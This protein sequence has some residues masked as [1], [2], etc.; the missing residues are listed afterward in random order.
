MMTKLNKLMLIVFIQIISIHG[1]TAGPQYFGS[2]VFFDGHLWEEGYNIYLC[3]G[4][5]NIEDP[6]QDSVRFYQLTRVRNTKRLY[7]KNKSET[8]PEWEGANYFAMIA[9]TAT[10][11]K[12]NGLATPKTLNYTYND[13]ISQAKHYTTQYTDD[14]H[15]DPALSGLYYI[16]LTQNG[17]DTF[18]MD[19]VDKMLS[20]KTQTLEMQVFYDET[21]CMNKISPARI[22]SV[23]LPFSSD[24][25]GPAYYIKS[26]MTIEKG[27][28]NIQKFSGTNLAC[29]SSL[30]TL[31]CTDLHEAYEFLGWWDETEQKIMSTETKYLYEVTGDKT[32][33][34][35]FRPKAEYRHRLYLDATQWKEEGNDHRF[36]AYAYNDL[37]ESE[38]VD[39]ELLTCSNL[40]TYYIGYVPAKYH[41]I[42]FCKMNPNSTTNDDS[43]V[44]AQAGDTLITLDERI[45]YVVGAQVTNNIY[46]GKWNMP[47]SF[48][49]TLNIQGKGTVT[50]NDSTY[51]ESAIIPNVILHTPITAITHADRWLFV[52][53]TTSYM[54][55]GS[56]DTIHL[57]E[58]TI[59]NQ[60]EICGSTTINVHFK[61][62]ICE[63]QFATNLPKEIEPA[64]SPLYV[65]YNTTI[66]YPSVREVTGYLFEGWYKDE[67]YK[68]RFDFNAPITEDIVLY[69]QW[70]DFSK[71]VFFK[72]NVN[73]DHV[74][75]YTFNDDAW[76]GNAG[77]KLHQ[78][79]EFGEM[80]QMGKTDIF[81][82]ILKENNDFS[83]IAFSDIDMHEAK[84]F[85][86]NYAIYRTDHNS[87]MP[88]FIPLR[89]QEVAITNETKYQSQ[90]IWMKYKSPESGYYWSRRTTE[91][92]ENISFNAQYLG[93]YSYL[94]QVTLFE[95]DTIE[96]NV[97][98]LNGEY[99]GRSGTMMVSD[100]SNWHLKKT[101]EEYTTI[102]SKYDGVYKFII[103]FGN[104]DIDISLVFPV[105]GY[106]GNNNGRS[107]Y[108]IVYTDNTEERISRIIYNSKNTQS[109]D[110]T[111]SFFVRHDQDPKLHIEYCHWRDGNYTP[112][113]NKDN[114]TK[115]YELKDFCPETGVY[116]FVFYQN[117]SSNYSSKGIK[118]E[119][120]HKYTGDYYIRS[121]AAEGG[122]TS[123]KL[124]KHKMTHSKYAEDNEDYNYYFYKWVN[125]HE[126]VKYTIADD[127]STNLSDTLVAD[128]IISYN[129]EGEAGCVPKDAHVRFMWNSH[130]NELSRSYISGYPNTTSRFLVLEGND[131]LKNTEG[132]T[133]EYG[134][135]NNN[136]YGLNEHEEIFTDL[137]D[138]KYQVDVK[139]N[140]NTQV[141]VSAQYND[142]VQYFK[143]GPTTSVN[144]LQGEDEANYTMR[145]IYD[146]RT[147]QLLTGWMPDDIILDSTVNVGSNMLIIRRNNEQTNQV[148]FKEQTIQV[149]AVDR[150]YSVMTFTKEFIKNDELPS[151]L[152]E[153]YWISFPYDVNLSD[154]FGFG[155]YG[156]HWILQYYDG[157]ERA[158]KGLFIDS[159]TY[160]KY[161]TDTN[162]MLQK[163]VGYVLVLDL[164]EVRKC[165]I[166]DVNE[167][168]LYFPSIGAIS[169]SNV[170]SIEVPAHQCNIT[171]RKQDHTITD[172]HWNLIG[173]PCY[174]D[175]NNLDVTHK[176]NQEDVTFY[177]EYDIANDVYTTTLN[178]ADFRTMY[179]YMVQFSGVIKWRGEQ[180]GPQEIIARHEEEQCILRLNIANHINQDHT[181][182]QLK[183]YGATKDFDMNQDLTKIL[184][185]GTNIYT[186]IGEN[187][188]QAA[189]N[190]LPIEQI[191]LPV[192][193]QVAVSGDYT[194]SMPDGTSGISAVLLDKKHDVYTNLLHN[195]YCVNLEAGVYDGRFYLIL[196]PSKVTTRTEEI[197]T[198]GDYI[199]NKYLIDG[200]LYIQVNGLLYDIFGRP[201]R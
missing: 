72:N 62:D 156:K 107:D 52:D 163:G 56:G 199:F 5:E 23:G 16:T 49:I 162:T 196:D 121:N 34:A 115:I 90:G 55:L 118:I 7:S 95:N 30:D 47:P 132:N 4:K 143:G 2:W 88:L 113:W 35:R 165:F 108:R 140:K 102:N 79:K 139:A 104:G 32:V 159:G 109:K 83:H 149:E 44:L 61:Q 36:A 197:V 153:L 114:T 138:A 63:I 112:Y 28:T 135:G 48:D 124:D 130:T 127:Y 54:Q 65:A 128:D 184:N 45:C 151:R 133:L 176:I 106:A 179:A 148:A 76:D 96:F 94:A 152:R 131:Q 167:L 144:L 120:T 1:L 189:G 73:W 186:L 51:S 84:N 110:D 3:I 141:K 14:Y 13:I 18:A 161:I 27:E 40:D 171:N 75:V 6:M 92:E 71:C 169:I 191:E 122:W 182:I 21:T 42:R 29:I 10:Y 59:D 117:Y 146:H 134:T 43:Q 119:A 99:Y 91:G 190:V 187:N 178:Q 66:S 145:L 160:W 181:Y 129:Y 192:G 8:V 33:Y 60:Y 31:S 103:Y 116:S 158:E 93:N 136:R 201:L 19:V 26:A 125:A 177:Y 193:V 98:N 126:E 69:G 70:L 67:N 22:R 170:D 101:E 175:I 85:E 17:D 64:I 195:D 174:A 97:K 89:G 37:G 183:E 58:N 80:N 168:R 68:V 82:I 15:I 77:V 57:K 41:S 25:N 194:F 105:Y 100:C 111:I 180:L 164:E 147:N 200:V 185:K 9:T 38:W 53:S 172:S 39:L 20:N 50:I 142:K 86:G 87:E 78:L 150:V 155:E 46:E 188:V 81:F 11:T 12:S 137:G 24:W 157:A 166:N 123:Y 173:V 74:Y 154:V 198:N